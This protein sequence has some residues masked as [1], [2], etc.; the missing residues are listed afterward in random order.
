MPNLLPF[1]VASFV[2]TVGSAIL[3]VIGLEALGLGALQETTL[4]NTIYWSQQSAAVLRG[5]VVVVGAADR[6]DRA[7]LPRPVPDLDRLRPVRQ[8][9]AGEAAHDRM[10]PGRAAVPGSRR[11]GSGAGRRRSA[12]A[13]RHQCRARRRRSTGSRSRCSPGERLGLIGESGLGQDDDGDGADA[14]H[15]PARPDRRRPR[16][17]RR[18]GPPAHERAERCA[19]IRL[20]DIALVPQGAMSS[21]NPV[22]RIGTRSPMPSSRTRRGLSRA[23]LAARIAELLARRRPRSRTSPAL[24]A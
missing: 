24:P 6:R 9:A 21:L 20:Q 3:A 15:P 7:H 8:P 13:L 14:A 18:R 17:A 11:R 19:Q 4:G 23:A 2:G 1:I 12:R 22:M 10:R 5:Y 16:P